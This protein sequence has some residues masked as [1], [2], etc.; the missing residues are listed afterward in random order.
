MNKL[1]LIEA[2]ALESGMTK[3]EAK[4]SLDAFMGLV[5]SSLYEGDKVT[6]SGF[7]TFVVEKKHARMGRDPRNGTPIKIAAKNVIKFRPSPELSD[8]IK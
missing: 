7:G 2:I 5:T 3:G 1:Q 4:R 6:L 8:K